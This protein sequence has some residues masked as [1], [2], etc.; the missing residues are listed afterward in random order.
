M[1]NAKDQECG[2]R[3]IESIDSCLDCEDAEVK[4]VSLEILMV[5]VKTILEEQVNSPIYFK[6]C[7]LNIRNKLM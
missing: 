4:E 3:L 1:T 7:S 6:I 5:V 2:I